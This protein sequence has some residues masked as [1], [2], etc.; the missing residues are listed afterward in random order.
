MAPVG[1][2]Q[3]ARG[4]LRALR[5]AFLDIEAP[6]RAVVAVAWPRS[7]AGVR[8]KP[9]DAAG[10]THCAPAAAVLLLLLE[11]LA[12]AA[13]HRRHRRDARL[14]VPRQ[15]PQRA[16]HV[17]PRVRHALAARPLPPVH[18]VVV[19]AVEPEYIKAKLNKP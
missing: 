18:A 8:L 16:A 11:V 10:A 9:A 12:R 5:L 6:G 3:L 17:Q 19:V 14:V 4:A 1:A 7:A 2:A 13:R 15:V